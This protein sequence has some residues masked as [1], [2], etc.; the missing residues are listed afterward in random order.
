MRRYAAALLFLIATQLHAATYPPRYHWR[1][2]TTDHFFIHFHQGEEDLAQRAAVIAERA[3]QRVVPMM[4]WEPAGRTDLVLTDH[5][6]LSNGSATPFTSNHIEIFV[7]APSDDPLS[8]IGYYDDWLNVAIV[9]EY[10]HILHL[11]QAR[12]FSRGVRSIF[13]R[14]PFFAFPNLFS[15]LWMTEG[16]ATLSESENTEAGRLK[17]THVDMVLRTAAIENRWASE[18]QA[19]GV[20]SRWPPGN[21]RYFYGSKFL[22]WLATTRGEGKLTQYFNDYSA[23]VIPFRV[24]AS[25][26]DV[27]GTDMKSLWMQW[28]EEQKR[29]YR[30]DEARIAGDGLTVHRRLTTTGFE[31]TSPILSPDGARIAYVFEGPFGRR[32]IR[33]LEVASGRDI[34]THAVNATSTLSWSPDGRAI[35]YADLDFVGSFALLSDLYV[36]DIDRGARRITTGARL[37]AP[38]FTPDGRTLIAVENGAGRNR[39]VEVD[40]VSGATRAIVEPEGY[41]QFGEPAVSHDG[42]RIAVAEWNRG[43]TDIV[44]YGRKGERLGNLTEALDHAI[45]ASPR[46]SADDSTIWFSSDVTGVA[47]LYSVSSG[48][49]EAHRLTNVYGGAFYP[50]SADGRRFY[51]CDYSSDGFDLATFDVTHDYPVRKRSI[52]ESVVGVAS[53][54]TPAPAPEVAGAPLPATEYSPWH[55]LRPRWWF[56]IIDSTRVNGESKPLLGFETGGADALAR[57]SYDATITNRSG[58]FAYSYD[59]F[60][61]TFTLAAS[62]SDENLIRGDREFTETTNRVLAQMSVPWRR[63]QWVAVGSAGLVHETITNEKALNGFRAGAVFS[64]AR[65]YLRSI[66]PEDGVTAAVNYENLQRVQQIRTDLRGYLSIPGVHHVLAVRGAGAWNSGDFIRQREVKVGGDESGNLNT[67]GLNDLPV[68]GFDLGALRGQRAVIGSIEYRFPLYEIDRG[69][70]TYPIFFNRIHGAVF[71]DAGRAAGTTIASA[72]AEVAADFIVAGALPLRY[73]LGVAIRLT[74]PGKSSVQPYIGIGSSF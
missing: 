62:R 19:N 6:D 26:T 17:G 47:N 1:T 64:S 54:A 59:R 23:N 9:H 63:F 43:A 21:A 45:N 28:S 71:S 50:T 70:T 22:S 27:Y 38:A 61:P 12:G 66:S 2:I 29:I 40:A 73:R 60:Y 8:P 46:F 42:T 37:K 30:S 58:A 34:A 53:Q 67:F 44:V 11:D 39:L 32:T 69:P 20:G 14:H 33:V 3:H 31:T 15:P 7:S 13:G 10:T 51:Y 5:V 49:G 55:T 4:G 52:P 35:A 57:H 72:G 16:I 25:A 65:E 74:N 24:N 41:R 68:R 48:G 56:P 36:W 18:A